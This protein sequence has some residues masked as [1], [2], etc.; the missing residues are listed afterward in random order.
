MLC[1]LQINVRGVLKLYVLQNLNYNTY[2]IKE[3]AI[4]HF[5]ASYEQFGCLSNIDLEEKS[6]I[7]LEENRKI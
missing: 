5:H 2:F 6:N 7:D 3:S 1:L 4:F